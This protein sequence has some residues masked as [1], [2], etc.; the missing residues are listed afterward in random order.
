LLCETDNLAVCK[1]CHSVCHA[2]PE[3]GCIVR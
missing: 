3:D 1:P 2:L